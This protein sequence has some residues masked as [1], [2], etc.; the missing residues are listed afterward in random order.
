MTTVA[1]NGAR[2]EAARIIRALL[3]SL[4][5]HARI[6]AARGVFLAMGIAAL[7]EVHADFITKARGG[8][9]ADGTRWPRLSPKTLAYSRRFG[10][11]EQAGLKREAG[12]GRANRLAPGGKSGLLTAAQLKE[13][14]HI[15]ASR[16]ARFAATMPLS[17]AK[18]KAAA[19]AWA[20]M[21]QRGAKTKLEVYG[22]REHE[23][24]RDTGVLANSLSV[25]SISGGSYQRPMVDGGE[26]QIFDLLEN[27]VIVGTNV[28]YARAHHE[29]LNGLPRRPIVPE[30]G[31]IPDQWTQRILDA[32]MRALAAAIE[33][34]LHQGRVA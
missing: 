22:N 10:P 20:V 27:G 12:L 28:R 31:R 24:L 30:E 6:D 2:N 25:G 21:K 4:T 9:G 14:R 1:F 7:T 19:I 29:G 26:Q 18:A 33:Q 8:T 23:V 17:E 3:A 13:W 11:G 15:Y 5:G 32:G 16:L 34:S